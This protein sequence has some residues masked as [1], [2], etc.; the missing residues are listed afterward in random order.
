MVYSVLGTPYPMTIGASTSQVT[1]CGQTLIRMGDMI[2]SGPG[3]MT[4]L[5]PPASP[6]V[7]DNTG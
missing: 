5:G 2:P 3:V 1:A 4:I 7:A 6:G